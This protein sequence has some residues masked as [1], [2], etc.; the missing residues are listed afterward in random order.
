MS[1]LFISSQIETLC[2]KLAQNLNQQSVSIFNQ[3][4]II[5]QGGG[6]NDWLTRSIT[7]TNGVFANFAFQNQDGFLGK[8]YELLTGEKLRSNRDAIKFGIYRLFDT[9]DFKKDFPYVASYFKDND[10]RRIQLSEKIADL[11]DQ[12]QLYRADMIKSW[13]EGKTFTEKSESEKWQ[14]W[15]WQQLQLPSK[16]AYRDGIYEALEKKESQ[17]LLQKT[18]PE[19]HLFGI[20]IY[21]NFHLE[22][23]KRL[24]KYITVH[25]Y[26]C[27]PSKEKDHRHTLLESFGAKAKELLEQ[28]AGM[29]AELT[30]FPETDNNTLLGRLQNSIVNNKELSEKGPDDSIQVTSHFTPVREVE[31]LF[32]YL[33]NLF[34]KDREL[35]PRDVL[36]ITPDINKYEPFVKAVFRNAPVN[37]PHRVSGAAKNTGDS[38]TA[39]LELISNLGEEDLTSEKVAGL[40]EQ[41]RIGKAYGVED[42]SYIR[43]VL[44][45]AGIRFGRENRLN[46][47]THYVSWKYGLEKIILGYAMLTEEPF[48]VSHRLTEEEK[49]YLAEPGLTN[50]PYRDAE[51]SASHDLFRLKA[52]VDDLQELLDEQQTPRTLTDWKLVF[53]E[54][55]MGKMVWSNDFDKED[56]QERNEIFRV[57]GF[58]ERLDEASAAVEVPW[59]V[60]LNELKKRLFTESREHELNTGAITFTSAIPARGLPYKVIA[61]IGLDNSVFPRQDNHLGFDLTGNDYQPG[62]RSKKEADKSLFLDTLMAARK[63]LYLNYIGQSVKDNTEI[64]P[65]IVLDTLMDYLGLKAVKHPLHGFSNRYNDQELFTYLYNTEPDPSLRRTKDVANSSDAE[66]PEDQKEEIWVNDFVKF[67][68][69]PIEYYFEKVLGIYLTGDDDITLPETEL[70]ELGRLQKW[71]IKNE[72]LKYT[73]STEEE[74]KAFIQEHIKKGKLPLKNLGRE[75]VEKMLEEIEPVK[76]EYIERTNGKEEK[77]VFIDLNVNGLR[78]T[79]TIDGVFGDEY[80]HATTSTSGNIDKYKVRAYLNALLLY[81]AGKI[82]SARLLALENEGDN[83]K[84]IDL[85][86]PKVETGC[87]KEKL[88]ELI[89]YL[90]KGKPQPLRFSL[91]A[92]KPPEGVQSI[93][94]ESVLNVLRAEAKGNKYAGM[95]PNKYVSALLETGYFERISEKDVDQIKKLAELLNLS[96]QANEEA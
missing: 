46:D 49:E 70:F 44:N 89:E 67:F 42:T 90:K 22:F 35:K 86:I 63:K 52:F 43:G 47:D 84:V 32:N 37:L 81:A 59:Q 76:K 31:A 55:V 87:A 11:F 85:A 40:L 83:I 71:Q 16:A 95:P 5:T 74:L 91:N 64:P 88:F 61:F 58:T 62:D 77:S 8:V 20:S 50:Y 38:I 65:S 56:R 51:A 19:I 73:G 41:N 3:S 30:D 78:I 7:E 72:L 29:K 82:T 4:V 94:T 92:T 6:V 36:V 26:L 28:F 34:L 69:A 17:E 12:Y 45:K 80:I 2:G 10:L 60:F 33:L 14:M 24:S 54:K 25:F 15:L 93:T 79:G 66:K 9:E 48:D 1:K 53:V 13:E 57:L 18:W 96:Q 39:S 21:T 23:Y 75:A 27:L 68:E